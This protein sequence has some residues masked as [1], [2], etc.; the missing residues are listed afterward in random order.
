MGERPPFFC[1]VDVNR[2][3]VVFDVDGEAHQ[4]VLFHVDAY[5]LFSAMILW[6]MFFFNPNV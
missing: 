4:D 1:H 3:R 2:F 6:S 5:F